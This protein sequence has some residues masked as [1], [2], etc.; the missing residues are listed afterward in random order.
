MLEHF[1]GRAI[2]AIKFAQEEARR[3]EFSMVNGGHLLMGLAAE[4]NGVA[5][6]ALRSL[7]F[8]LRKARTTAE[9]LW[10]RGYERAE[11]IVPSDEAQALL[12]RACAIAEQ[13]EPLLVDTQDLLRA[14]LAYP[15]GRGVEL[16]RGAGISPD[17]LLD[18][19]MAER[20]DEL[21]GTAATAHD[22]G[23]PKHFHPR[24]L[25]PQARQVLELAL[26]YT[27][28]HGHTIVGTEQLLMGLLDVPDGGASRLLKANGL[29]RRDVEAFAHRVIGRGSGTIGRPG[30]SKW[31]DEALERSWQ[32]AK[33]LGHDQVGTVHILLGLLDLDSGGALH[34]MDLL[35]VNLS[36]IQM[37]AEQAFADHPRELEPALR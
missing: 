3:L 29:S 12:G 26:D 4:G 10:G 37:D 1:S 23:P 14:I 28:S 19:V 9:R 21:A 32:A 22:T 24:L 11:E 13:C 34:L 27:R 30:H 35:K 20:S 15:S 17:E 2:E 31:V 18:R 16:L 7:G 5:A 36:S 8:D 33:R 6:R 25:A